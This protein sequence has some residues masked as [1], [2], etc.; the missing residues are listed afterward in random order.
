MMKLVR[1][2]AIIAAGFLACAPAAAQR[3]N[4]FPPA[5]PASG[6]DTVLAQQPSLCMSG[7]TCSGVLMTL[8]QIVGYAGSSGTF[9]PSDAD[10]A[11][12]AALT[13]S[14]TARATTP[15]GLSLLTQPDAPTTRNTLG[16]GSNATDSTARVPTSLTIST[17]APLAGGGT[18][19]GNLALS[20]GAA[21]SSAAGTMSAADKSK[22]DGITGTNTGDQTNVTGN[23]G[24][25]TKL[26]TPRAI[27]G[28]PFDG[29]AP[30]TINASD[31][32]ARLA[33]S[34]NL[35]DVAS[36]AAARTN[37]GLGTAATA[38]TGTSGAT[39]PL[40]NTANT[41]GAA[42]TFAAKIVGGQAA[43]SI[44]VDMATADN[45]FSVRVLANMNASSDGIYLGYNNGNNGLTRLFGGGAGGA[46]LNMGLSALVPSNDGAVGIGSASARLSSIYAATVLGTTVQTTGAST[47]SALVTCNTA[48]RGTRSVVTDA[49][50]PTFLSPLMGGGSVVAPVFC[51]GSAWV[52]G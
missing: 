16:L 51:N 44:G 41:W 31:T 21:T 14:P 46:S 26:A 32:T 7:T 52:A 33:V 17:A 12:I 8:N 25:A 4:A 50:A 49:T 40:L 22:L 3:L 27:N 42:Q 47:V 9:Q 23:A 48:A 1:L 24:T 13:S 28:V 18:L 19:T 43:G 45:Y 2:A 20:I 30:I 38:N 6:T 5:G 37:L 39:V 10:L 35:S 11:A 29:S 15:F 36:V 34:N